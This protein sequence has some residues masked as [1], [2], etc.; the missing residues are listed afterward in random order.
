MTLIF[1]Y[2]AWPG[3]GHWESVEPGAESLG[4]NGGSPLL[5]CTLLLTT[6][7]MSCA[8]CKMIR[9]RP[10]IIKETERLLNIGLKDSPEGT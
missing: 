7:V 3:E 9:S 1:N 6:G 5:T 2:L 4:G 10:K 8:L